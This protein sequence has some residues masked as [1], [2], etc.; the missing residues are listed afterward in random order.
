MFRVVDLRRSTRQNDRRLE[1]P[2]T[3]ARVIGMIGT[4]GS[5]GLGSVLAL[6]HATA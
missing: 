6:M 1:K 2:I 5:I 3:V 4:W